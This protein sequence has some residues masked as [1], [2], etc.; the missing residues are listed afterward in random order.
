VSLS[1]VGFRRGSGETF[2]PQ[3]YLS[4]RG[5]QLER[6]LLAIFDSQKRGEG[7]EV[8]GPLTHPL[9]REGVKKEE[10]H[11]VPL[12]LKIALPGRE[13]EHRANIPYA[14]GK[15]QSEERR[16]PFPASPFKKKGEA[17]CLRYTALGKANR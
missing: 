2:C 7:T 4:Y 6:G 17:P 8:R 9:P 16:P 1:Y 10:R 14:L 11:S 3:R 13:G 5:R 15:S 12:S